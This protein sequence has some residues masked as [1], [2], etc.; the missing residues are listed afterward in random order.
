MPIARYID[1]ITTTPL[2]MYELGHLAH[3]STANTMML[4]GSD[5]LMIAAGILSACLDRQRQY[6]MMLFYFAVSCVF[7]VVMLC[8]INVRLANGTVLQQ[9]DSVQ[10]LFGYL[11]V[12]TSTVWTFY[13]IVVFLGRA[14]CHLISK[15]TEDCLLCLLDITAKLGVEGLIIAFAVFRVEDAEGSDGSA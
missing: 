2:L 9:T 14:Q 4:V 5:I 12:L 8:I 13:P 10:E 6:R 15:N 3:A 7:Y 11:K 1:W